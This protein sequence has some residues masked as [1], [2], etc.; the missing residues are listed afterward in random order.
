MRHAR[1]KRG[2]RERRDVLRDMLERH[3]ATAEAEPLSLSDPPPEPLSDAADTCNETHA[4]I[5]MQ[6]DACGDVSTDS[7]R[8]R[9]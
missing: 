1:E 2:M 3:A 8:R 9:M 7:C 6:L 5:R 4:S